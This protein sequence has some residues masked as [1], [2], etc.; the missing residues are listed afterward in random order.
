[1]KQQNGDSWFFAT[2]SMEETLR[3]VTEL[4]RILSKRKRI[5]RMSMEVEASPEIMKGGRK[6]NNH[7]HIK[8]SN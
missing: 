4:R 5:E 8:E 3:W 1:L 7:S 6:H 2:D